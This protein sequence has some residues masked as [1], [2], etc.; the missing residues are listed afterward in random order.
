MRMLVIYCHPRPESFTAS[1]RD[2][3]IEGLT[4]AGHEIELVDL[5]ADNFDPRLSASEHENYEDPGVNKSGI[6][7]YVEQLHAAE[8]IVF[9]FPTWWYD[10]PAMLKGWL[11]RVWVPGVAFDL[12]EGRTIRP[13]LQHIRFMG[14]VTTCGAPWWWSKL[15]GE[16]HRRILM[17]GI[18]ALC[19]TRCKQLWLGCYKMDD[20]TPK[21]RSTFLASI[22]RRMAQ[23]A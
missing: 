13:R 7:R 12:A 10:M 2:A 3:V 23:V 9:V 19:G 14:A 20:S 21:R 6:E 18:R 17:R 22:R 5:Y 1:V 11:D 4:Q 16:P 8:G 15:V